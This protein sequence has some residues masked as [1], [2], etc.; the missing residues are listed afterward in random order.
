[1]ELSI[2]IL[3][4][5]NFSYVKIKNKRISIYSI[6]VNL[7]GRYGKGAVLSLILLICEIKL[8]R[9][10]IRDRFTRRRK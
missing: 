1:M 7:L 8:R 3:M 4:N 9:D 10:T 6:R 5:I 2:Q